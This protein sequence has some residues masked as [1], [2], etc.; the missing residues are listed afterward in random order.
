MARATVLGNLLMRILSAGLMVPFYIPSVGAADELAANPYRPSVGSPASLSAPGYFEGEAGF[1]NETAGNIRTRNMPM[2]LKYAFTD[3][4]G[5]TLGISPWMEVTDPAGNNSGNS[6]GAVTLKL[7]QPINRAL[8]LG[9]ELT[10][11]VP[12]A[13]SGL[14]SVHSDVTLNLI[15]SMD[16]A[17]F[18]SDLNL[19]S[20]RVG[21]TPALGGTRYITAG[22][23]GLSHAV[24]D[25]WGATIEVSGSRQGVTSSSTQWL[26]ALNYTV[27]PRWVLDAYAARERLTPSTSRKFGFGM[28]YLFAGK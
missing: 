12:V 8:M 16:F 5:V 6:N 1:A 14:G 22:S 24:N 23:A 26:G 13:S 10:V 9:S 28:T 25:H 17:G 15:A 7:A 3:R 11:S 18:H 27:N 19:N 2:L 4:I 21:D 20:T